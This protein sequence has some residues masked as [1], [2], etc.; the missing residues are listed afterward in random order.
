VSITFLTSESRFRRFV[1]SALCVA[2][3]GSSF[4]QAAREPTAKRSPSP[5]PAVVESAASSATGYPS[6]PVKIMV[7]AAP[8]GGTDILARLLAEKMQ[9]GTGQPFIVENRAGASNTIA[10]DATAKA[11]P[12]GHTLLVA[13]NTGQAIAPHLIRLGYDPLK[14][15][16]PIGMVMVVPN[17]LV[18][19]PNVKARNVQELIAEI[20]A[21]PNK[22]SYASSGIGSTQHIAGEAFALKTGLKLLHVPYRGSSQAHIDLIGGSVQMMFDTSSSAMPQIQGGKLR[23]L[24]VTSVI[25]SRALP[26]VPTLGEAGVPDIDMSTWYGLYTTGGTSDERV[27]AMGQELKRVLALP[28]VSKRIKDMGGINIPMYGE[29]FRSFNLREYVSYRRLITAA[30]IQAQ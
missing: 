3:A 6:K 20:R 14:D 2:F 22:Y 12:D 13:T 11:A 28:D 1:F 23:P 18:V 15:I 16:T 30:N 19:G 9:Q 7:G 29:N 26:D 10:A 17:V 4:S 8:G 27:R 24:A 21:N 25:R 5:M